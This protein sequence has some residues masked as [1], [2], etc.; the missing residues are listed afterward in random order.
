MQELL[1]KNRNK[2]IFLASHHPFQSYGTHGGYFSWKDHIF[3]LT[4][5]NENLYVPLPVVGSLYPLLRKTF[6]NPEDL[7]H[8]LYKNMIRQVDAVFDSFPNLIHIAGHEHGLQ[9]IKDKQVQVVSGS[10][11]QTDLC[12]KRKKFSFCSKLIRVL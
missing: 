2:I 1:Y 9:F 10:G 6:T 3:P 7:N 5:A 4:A 11:C 8:P 12:K